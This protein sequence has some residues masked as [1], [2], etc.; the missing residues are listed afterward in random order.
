[1]IDTFQEL[2]E[3]PQETIPLLSVARA[4]KNEAQQIGEIEPEISFLL[5]SLI[6]KAEL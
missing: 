4:Y 6:T 5:D 3:A 1:M 2:G